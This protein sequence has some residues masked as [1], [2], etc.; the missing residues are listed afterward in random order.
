MKRDKTDVVQ[1]VDTVNSM[2]NP[3]DYEQDELIHITSG[4]V[5]TQNVQTDLQSANARG[6][7]EFTK[8]CEQHLQTGTVD[9]YHEKTK[10]RDIH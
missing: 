10:S 4:V 8:F 5:T 3:F 7:L 1:I 2:I 6:E 9:C